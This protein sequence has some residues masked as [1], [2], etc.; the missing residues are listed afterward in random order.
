MLYYYSPKC[1]AEDRAKSFS[2][3]V[4]FILS[5]FTFSLVIVSYAYAGQVTLAWDA[6]DGQNVAGY[7]IYYGSASGDYR[8]TKNVGN[9]TTCTIESL[10]DGEMY[11]FA[12]TARD[13]Y[14][15]ESDFSEEVSYLAGNKP[16][17]ANAGPDQE[18]HGGDKV[19]LSAIN[20]SDPEGGALSYKWTQTGGTSVNLSDPNAAEVDFI[21]PYVE[22]GGESLTFA[23]QVTDEWGAKSQASC[24]V[25]IISANLPPVAN[26]GSQ[27]DVQELEIVKLDGSASRDPDG[28]IDSYSW[29]Q[30][31]GP[32]VEVLYP[33][34]AQ[35][36]FVAPGVGPEGAC[37][38]FRL[39]VRDVGGLESSSTC[40]V[41]VTWIN[42]PPIANAGSD[43]QVNA[44]K[45]A[46]LDGSASTDPDDGIASY[47]WHQ[48]SGSPVTLNGSNTAKPSFTAPA[49][50]SLLTTLTFELTVTDKGGLQ[51]TRS[52][53]V[54]V[55]SR[56]SSWKS[57]VKWY[58]W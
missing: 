29:T 26:A 9:V 14:N 21:A 42:E 53:N 3:L 58:R 13:S 39:T 48:T 10:P 30:L 55:K 8:Y 38:T 37:L 25:N 35:A 49:F 44:G 56:V 22:P 43:Q 2:S 51:S 17:T 15:N 36:S 31:S 1:S 41:N 20:S 11:Y 47:Q 46:V 40:L 19:K 6:S 54:Y 27:Q 23:L 50:D 34:M 4:L 5:L 33:D 24:R 52:C 12:A 18:S 28:I 57:I 32:T 16:P 45:T 7:T